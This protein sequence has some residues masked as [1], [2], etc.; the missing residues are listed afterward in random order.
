MLIYLIKNIQ[1]KKVYIGKTK[2]DPLIRFKGHCDVAI[3]LNS[4]N[5]FHNAIRKHGPENFQLSILGYCESKEELD[6][7]EKIC[8]EHF[9]SNDKRYGYNMTCGGDGGATRCGMKNKKSTIEKI[10]KTKILNGTLYQSK[11]IIKKRVNTA[12][13]NKSFVGKNNPAFRNDIDTN[14]IIELRK[15]GMALRKIASMFNC[16][17]NLIYSRLRMQ[18]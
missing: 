16:S 14:K 8:I 7:A 6:E 4:N 3:K 17:T 5:Y 13:L 12:K 2:N 9:Q 11:E 1:T 18:E 10:I 15:D